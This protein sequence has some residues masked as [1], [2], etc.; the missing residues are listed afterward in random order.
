[1]HAE[2]PPDFPLVRV[3]ETVTFYDPVDCMMWRMGGHCPNATEQG[4]FCEDADHKRFVL[5]QCS[6]CAQETQIGIHISDT[7]KDHLITNRI[8]AAFEFAPEYQERIAMSD[9]L[10]TLQKSGKADE[11]RVADALKAHGA[12]KERTRDGARWNGLRW[13]Q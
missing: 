12:T 6:L 11:M 5:A 1:M 10:G 13:R 8:L 3:I 2:F 7:V 4:V 9:I